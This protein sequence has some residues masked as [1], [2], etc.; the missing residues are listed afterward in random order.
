VIH[1]LAEIQLRMDALDAFI[2]AFADLTRLVRA[3]DGCIE[4]Q[5][6]VEIATNITA[7]SPVRET[8]FTVI[9]KW[10]DTDALHA[11][12]SALHMTEYRSQTTALVVDTTIRVLRSI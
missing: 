10:R 6:A 4:Y 1:V 8:V 12:L 9:E 7:Q 5:G 3:E 2:A 11:H